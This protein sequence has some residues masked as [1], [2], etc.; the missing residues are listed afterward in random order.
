MERLELEVNLRE[1]TGKS[2]ARKLRAAGAIPAVVYGG[3]KESLALSV[4]ERALGAVLRR[5]TNQIIDLKGGDGFNGRLVL[6]KDYQRDPLSRRVMHCDFYEV[7]TKQKIDVQV[8]IVVTG[9]SKGVE[10]QGGVLDVVQREVAVKCLPLAIPDSLTIDVS[11]LDIGD[12]L[13]ISDLVLPE[14]VELMTDPGHTLVHVT[15]PRIEEEPEAEA[16]ELAAEGV[17]VEGE[18]PAEGEGKPEEKAEAKSEG[19]AGD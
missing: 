4:D 18:A 10:Q 13:H 8:P 5:G 14:G 7:D 19:S 1:A 15:A 9:K 6:L 2:G 3:G 12:A 17:A 16:E 11:E